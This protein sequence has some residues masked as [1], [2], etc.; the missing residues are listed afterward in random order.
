MGGMDNWVRF[1]Y[2]F[3][4]VMVVNLVRCVKYVG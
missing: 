1:G 2:M 3:V 4:G